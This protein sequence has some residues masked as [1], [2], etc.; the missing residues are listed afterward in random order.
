[1][2]MVYNENTFIYKT[3]A[4]VS[5]YLAKAGGPTRDA[6]V[7]RIYLLRA[8]GTVLSGQSSD[9]I[10]NSFSNQELIPGDTLVVPEMLDKFS[11]TRDLKDSSQIFYQFALGVAGLKVLGL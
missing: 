4:R 9:S 8:D 1:M 10:F 5:D 11:F 3:G 2:G 6:D 7:S